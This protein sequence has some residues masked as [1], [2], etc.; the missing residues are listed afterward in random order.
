[1]CCKILKNHLKNN[2]IEIKNASDGGASSNFDVREGR[3]QRLTAEGFSRSPGIRVAV[4]I[5]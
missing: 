1:V 2:Q 5:N 4:G 3:V